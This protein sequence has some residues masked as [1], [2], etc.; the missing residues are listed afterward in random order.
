[1]AASPAT[2][3][4]TPE[5]SIAELIAARPHLTMNAMDGLVIDEGV[6]VEIVAPG[7]GEPVAEG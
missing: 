4:D 2:A 3:A 7:S 1:M 5:P 6:L